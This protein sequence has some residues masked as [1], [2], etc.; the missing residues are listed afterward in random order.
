MPL[1]RHADPMIGTG[2]ADAAEA[3]GEREVAD[4]PCAAAPARSPESAQVAD[5]VARCQAGEAGAFADLVESCTGRLFN[6]LL[7]FT[8]NAHDAE[9]LVQDTFV[10]VHRSLDRFDARR[11][12]FPWLFT[13]ARRTALNH[14]RGRRPT[15]DLNENL[16]APEPSGGAAES[17]ASRDE[18]DRLWGLARRLKPKQYEVLW[19]R[20]GEGLDVAQ[21]AAVMRTRSLYVRVLL[22]RARTALLQATRRAGLLDAF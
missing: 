16:P 9:D 18:A 4:T 15:E 22:H 12:F 5:L 21:V 8:G 11:D 2:L 17:V 7:R 6:F 19:L 10:K 1:A 14:L 20:Y 13:I 3:S